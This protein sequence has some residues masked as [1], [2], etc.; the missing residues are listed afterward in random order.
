MKIHLVIKYLLVISALLSASNLH[1]SRAGDPMQR[2]GKDKAM[3]AAWSPDG[4]FIAVGS[5]DYLAVYTR[6]LEQ[7]AAFETDDVITSLVWNPNNQQIATASRARAVQLWDFPSGAK[8]TLYTTAIADDRYSGS[9]TYSPDGRL[10]A[11]AHLDNTVRIWDTETAELVKTLNLKAPA[12][13]V[14][15]HP[16]G[17]WIAVG[18]NVEIESREGDTVVVASVQIWDVGTTQIIKRLDTGR[19]DINEMYTQVMAS[20]YFIPVRFLQWYANGTR[21]LMETS[22]VFN[23][24]G[25]WDIETD[26]D[27]LDRMNILAECGTSNKTARFAPDGDT[28]AMGEVVAGCGGSGS[29]DA[30][31]VEIAS[32]DGSVG[33]RSLYVGGGEIR[34]ITWH[35]D[36]QT[37][38]V[39]ASDGRV[40]FSS[41]DP[42]ESYQPVLE[43]EA[44]LVPCQHRRWAPNGIRWRQVCDS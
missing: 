42:A 11:S 12:F 40:V 39:V 19:E 33:W 38:A 17:E 3:T 32:Q 31:G 18:S 2:P 5:H 41:F 37:F 27:T 29:A 13:A 21:L 14:A 4:E 35:P 25:G 28:L 43:R 23:N 9:V 26:G 20:P 24:E 8:H 22:D 36:N 30:W 10:L 15:W 6:E 7:V 44:I 1:T 16:D 34:D